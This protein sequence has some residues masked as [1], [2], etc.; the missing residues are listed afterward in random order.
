LKKFIGLSLVAITL[1]AIVLAVSGC[2]SPT[3]TVAPT[4]APTAIVNVTVT[5]AANVTV[6]PAANVT[7]TPAPNATATPVPANVHTAKIGNQTF[8]FTTLAPGKLAVATD[9]A[10]E[11]FENVNTATNKIEGFDIDLMDQIAKDLNL[12]PEYTNQAFDSII[13]SI[14][15]KKFDTSISAFTI[16]P[17]RQAS[18]DFTDAYFENKGQAIAVKPG[19]NITKPADLVGHK[20]AVQTGTAGQD[21]VKA[22]PNMTESD[23]KFYTIMPDVM[24]ALKKGEV[25]A[26]AGDYAVMLPYVNRYPGDYQFAPEFLSGLE[27]FGIINNKDDKNL[28][29]AMNAALANM[30]T[31]GQYQTI[32]NKWFA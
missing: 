28:T 21:A 9:A 31:N 11:P 20:V 24:L 17:E 8:T 29:A 23:I 27:Y 25:D 19:S 18:V 14:Q 2:A 12:T 30:K 4:A 15:T 6:T 3:P 26:A 22:I 16:K 10:Y 5:P 32:Y 7:V 1:L 13:L